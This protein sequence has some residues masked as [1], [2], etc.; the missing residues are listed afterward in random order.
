VAFETVFARAPLRLGLAGGGTDVSP[1]CDTFGGA[2]VNATINLF[3]H[4][5]IDWIAEPKV[6][7]V[8][9]DMGVCVECALNGSAPE[10]EELPIHR[11]VHREA[12]TWI[13]PRLLPFMRVTT[14]SDCPPGSGVGSSSALVVCMLRAYATLLGV[15]I[16]NSTIAAIAFRIERIDCAMA[17]GRQ[18]QYS[19]ALGGFNFLEF[20]P[21]GNTTSESLSI[22]ERFC[23]DLC[24]HFVLFYTGKS[25]VS[26][27]IIQAQ[28]QAV[29][30]ANTTAV[31]AM[32]V[33]KQNALLMRE[34]LLAGN[35][36]QVLTIFCGAWNNKK[37]LAANIST[38]HIETACAA[39]MAAGARGMKISGAGGGGFLVVVVA[40][41]NRSDVERALLATGGSLHPFAFHSMGATAERIVTSP[42]AAVAV[43]TRRS[44]T[45]QL[46]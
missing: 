34:A 26:S 30:S 42:D 3:T 40:P 33:L 37:R 1:Y 16:D 44:T 7:F 25:R 21:S 20:L 18:D 46:A 31:S 9:A 2:V 28:A 15:T 4:C 45:E 39:A 6:V 5:R 14:R 12:Q 38:P 11:A 41:E 23:D 43:S 17:G 10:A 22:S 35:L 13:A 8:A 29:R 19:A 27:E 36:D 32:H 24:A